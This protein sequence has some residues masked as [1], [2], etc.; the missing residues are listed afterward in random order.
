MNIGDEIEVTTII[1]MTEIGRTMT[2]VT[3]IK[4]KIV[5][6]AEAKGELRNE[7]TTN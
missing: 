5:D 6:G 3:L 1:M 7:K 4:T 2:V